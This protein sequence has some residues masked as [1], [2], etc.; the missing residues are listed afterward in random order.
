MIGCSSDYRPL[1]NFSEQWGEKQRFSPQKYR[2]GLAGFPDWKSKKTRAAGRPQNARRPRPARP[3]ILSAMMSANSNWGLLQGTWEWVTGNL[4]IKSQVFIVWV[5]KLVLSYYLSFSS[6]P[7][8][9]A[10]ALM[11]R[12][13]LKTQVR[14]HFQVAFF[15][16]PF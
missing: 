4:G 6:L 8:A 1:H 3:W 7:L 2:A 13:F 10:A 11:A 9:P 5:P 14:Q 12:H 15:V 16:M